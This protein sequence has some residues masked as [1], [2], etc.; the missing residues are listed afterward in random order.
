MREHGPYD[1]ILG[2]SQG[3]AMVSVLCA[4]QHAQFQ[5]DTQDQPMFK[6]AIL[7]GGFVP[8]DPEI[9]KIMPS[10][11]QIPSFHIFGDIDDTVSP[12]RSIELSA[13]F[14]DPVIYRHEAGHF[15]PTNSAAAERYREFLSKF[16]SE[17]PASNL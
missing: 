1:G 7:C 9:R 3:A 15:I 6:F 8:R 17:V 10:L 12:K 13:L 11:I 4:L 5:S 16:S 14:Q 2:F